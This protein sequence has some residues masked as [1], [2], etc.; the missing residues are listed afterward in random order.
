MIRA[1]LCVLMG[2]LDEADADLAALPPGS[3]L[4]SMQYALPLAGI[5]AELARAGG[6]PE[7]AREL[8]AETERAEDGSDEGRYR[9]PLLWQ[10]MQIEAD[11]AQEARDRRAELPGEVVARRAELLETASEMRPG[12]PP[13]AARSA[14]LAAEDARLREEGEAQAWA[15]AVRACRESDEAYP[16]AYALFRRAEA[17]AT[18]SETEAAEAAAEALGVATE[19]GA[20]PLAREIEALTRRARLRTGLAGSSREAAP[21]TAQ[22]PE[23]E[24]GLTP[25]EREV[26]A[27]VADGRS[28]G[29]I[30]ERLFITTK[31]ASVHVSNILAKLDVASRVEAA[32][33]AHRRGLVEP[34]DRAV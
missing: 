33:L 28:N 22:E 5:R 34:E 30:A 6:H 23:D 9:W 31:T 29:Q 27:L 17:L 18:E 32:A 7:Q 10:A 21:I 16:L 12:S 25:R 2:R 26:L 24:F 14:L 1:E 8:I 4:Q 3:D 20:V 19:V 15:A 11:I 13:E